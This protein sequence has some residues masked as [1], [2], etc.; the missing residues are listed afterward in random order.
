M[1]T[2]A[3]PIA[4]TGKPEIPPQAGLPAAEETQET[5]SSEATTDWRSKYEAAEAARTKV[6]NDLKALRGLRMTEAQREERMTAILEEIR[7]NAD[8]TAE[9]KQTNAA[10]IKALGN[11]TT[12][13]LPAEIEKLQGQSAQTRAARNFDL[14]YRSLWEDF[15]GAIQDTEGNPILDL[16]KAPELEEARKTWT[17]AY[18]GTGMSAEERLVMFAKGIAQANRATKTALRTRSAAESKKVKDDAQ[19]ATKKRLDDAGVLDLDT[20]PEAGGGGGR[21]KSWAQAQKI[22]KMSDL[23]DADYEKLIAG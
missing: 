7:R 22:K 17:A 16:E 21:V 9:I 6:E 1:T 20:G 2:Q 3:H 23:S 13:E 18:N 5:Q 14:Q 19:A 12:E 15:Q 10:L 8:D 11:N 4:T